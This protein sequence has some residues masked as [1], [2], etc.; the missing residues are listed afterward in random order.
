[1]SFCEFTKF[2]KYLNIDMGRRKSSSVTKFKFSD[3]I[4]F[5]NEVHPRDISLKMKLFRKWRWYWLII[6][7]DGIDWSLYT[8]TDSTLIH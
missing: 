7:E 5:V 8:V 2:S 1:M 3:K 6:S 4:L